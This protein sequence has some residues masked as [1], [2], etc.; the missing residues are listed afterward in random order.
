MWITYTTDEPSLLTAEDPQNLALLQAQ[1]EGPLTSNFAEAG[2]FIRTS[3]GLDAP[4]VQLHADPDPVPRRRR[5]RDPRRR[6]GDVRLLAAT[7]Q[8][9]IREAARQDS[10]GQA[11][12]SPQLP[13]ERRGPRHD[14]GWSE[15]VP[16]D[17][18]AAPVARG[19]HR[20]HP[21]REPGT[22]L[23][24]RLHLHGL[25]SDRHDTPLQHEPRR[26]VRPAAGVVRL[27]AAT[28]REH[29]RHQRRRTERGCSRPAER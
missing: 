9:R 14:A 28:R 25:G 8:H 23:A 29:T 18:R 15:E 11:P 20:R 10:D 19:H 21:G 24:V 6:M 26:T 2:G 1:G 13:A 12:D 4:D 5:G 7:D 3:D 16:G 17:R 22:L 27:R